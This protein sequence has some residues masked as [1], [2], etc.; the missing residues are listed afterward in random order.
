MVRTEKGFPLKLEDS[1][2]REVNWKNAFCATAAGG[3]SHFFID[4]FYHWEKE[5]M[6][7][8]SLA[9]TQD[10]ML[11]WSGNLYHVMDPLMVIGEAIVV[12]VI[13]LSFYYF[14]KGYKET[15]EVFLI[16]TA[17][18]LIF[19]IFVSTAIYGGEREY[20]VIVGSTF[21][22][23]I[24]LGLLFY[25]ARDILDHPRTIPDKPT[26]QRKKLLNIVATISLLLGL[27]MT[28]YALLAI[29]MSETIVDLIGGLAVATPQQI[30]G[31]GYYYG[32]IAIIQLVGSIGLYF[33]IKICRYL[34]IASSLYFL[35]F[36]FPIAIA[37]FLCEKDVK[38]L[39][40]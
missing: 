15:I 22:T 36:G 31:L 19:M 3:F 35:I 10:E 30:Q 23:L 17:L 21:Y 5:M 7:W 9:F 34:V 20:A 16:A 6:L 26:I 24:P 25:A 40:G 11:A 28:L 12:V 18:S 27:F 37:F 29:F 2:I 33:K 1:G 39:F 8:P 38:E 32:I 14:R 13:L 4:Q